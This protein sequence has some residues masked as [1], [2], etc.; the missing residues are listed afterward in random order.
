MKMKVPPLIFMIYV[1]L[2]C[3]KNQKTDFNDLETTLNLKANNLYSNGSGFIDNLD[4]CTYIGWNDPNPTINYGDTTV[5]KDI[6]NFIQCWNSKPKW[7]PC[8]GCGPSLKNEWL[9]S[10]LDTAHNFNPKAVQLGSRNAAL[11]LVTNGINRMK[12]LSPSPIP[13][14]NYPTSLDSNYRKMEDYFSDQEIKFLDNHFSLQSLVFDECF[15]LSKHGGI[16]LFDSESQGITQTYLSFI[17]TSLYD[18]QNNFFG[19]T[20]INTNISQENYY[21]QVLSQTDLK[22]DIGNYDYIAYPVDKIIERLHSSDSIAV[23]TPIGQP[24][25]PFNIKLLLPRWYLYFYLNDADI[26]KFIYKRQ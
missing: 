3:T 16:F 11:A 1:L 13:L 14:P 12:G 6:K 23:V 25:K 8:L 9:Q 20:A 22:N 21:P 15:H 7:W 24:P 17:N 10:L 2:S 5:K 26:N 18:R 4:V 19:S